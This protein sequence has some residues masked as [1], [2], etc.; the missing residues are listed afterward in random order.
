VH[1]TDK[2]LEVA[3]DFYKNL[4]KKENRGNF[5]LSPS[6]WGGEDLISVGE[7]SILEIPFSKEEVKATIS[8]CYPEGSPG[9]DGQSLLFY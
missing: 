8:S 5:S 6:F 3:V 9:P 1:E 2:I 7:C 4:F